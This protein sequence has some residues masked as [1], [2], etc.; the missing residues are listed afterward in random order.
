MHLKFYTEFFKTLLT[1]LF[2]ISLP[3]ISKSLNPGWIWFDQSP[4]PAR[5]YFEPWISMTFVYFYGISHWNIT[6]HPEHCYCFFTWLT[7]LYHLTCLQ[8]IQNLPAT[9]PFLPSIGSLPTFIT[10]VAKN[11]WLQHDVHPRPPLLP[12]LQF[13]KVVNYYDFVILH[14]TNVFFTTC[15]PLPIMFL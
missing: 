12:S 7:P 3:K 9:N 6:N 2:W 10:S 4:G 1:I 5:M 15:S 14:Y 13:Q 11:H 8:F